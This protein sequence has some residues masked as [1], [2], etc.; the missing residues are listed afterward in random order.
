VFF[1]NPQPFIV[2]LSATHSINV[3]WNYS[4]FVLCL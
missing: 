3:G 2:S 4:E 1:L